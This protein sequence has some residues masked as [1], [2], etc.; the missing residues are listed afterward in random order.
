MMYI[1]DVES[2]GISATDQV[3]ELGYYKAKTLKEE[4]F[5]FSEFVDKKEWI[6]SKL[7]ETIT[8]RFKPSVSINPRAQ[9]VHGIS[10]FSLT[11]EPKSSSLTLPE[12]S[13]M[14]GHNIIFDKR[15]IEQSNK[16]LNLSSMNLICTMALA[17]VV[18]KHKN[19]P[20][21]DVKLITLVNFYHPEVLETINT[22]YH[23]ASLDVIKTLLL[24][25]SLVK[26]FP[27]IETW[28]D[29]FNFQNNLKKVKRYGKE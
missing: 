22:K 17:K 8:Q 25:L 6:T 13:F 12:M 19:V 15:L 2:T 26:E 7:K 11:K 20:F 5:E 3:I 27:V 28:E 4:S 1:C 9:E 14:L 16:D 21:P 24:V 29:V 18:Q 23:S 10:L